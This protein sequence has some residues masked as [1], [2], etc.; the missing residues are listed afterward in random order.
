MLNALSSFCESA[1]VDAH[2][3]ANP[4]ARVKRPKIERPEVEPLEPYDGWQLLKA[5]EKI[6]R[7]PFY[8][9]TP[10][11][12]A[13]VAFFLLT[14]CRREE[15]FATLVTDVDFEQGRIWFR[16]NAHYGKRK[17]KKA[18]RWVPL[19]SQLRHY[20][21]ALVGQRESGLLFQSR[22]GNKL[23]DPRG[24]L[25]RV[26]S[27]AKVLKLEGCEWHLFRHTW[28]SLRLQTLDHG[29]PVSV[30]TVARELGHTNLKQIEETYG[31][32]LDTRHREP[33]VVYRPKVTTTTT[34]AQR[35]A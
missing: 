24:I 5:A 11:L 25:T 15:G 17:S 9:G 30:F 14:G 6:E 31:H 35:V 8:R 33:E 27:E 7:E 19:F 23:K 21:V 28:T 32:V 18:V 29:E 16:P 3:E 13:L 20:L 10:N 4:V 12:A 26:F 1:L 22:A 2:L 34:R